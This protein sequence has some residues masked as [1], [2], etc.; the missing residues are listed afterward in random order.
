MFIEVL[1]DM[2]SVF[3]SHEIEEVMRAFGRHAQ[4]L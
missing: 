3:S 4:P 2:G 1:V